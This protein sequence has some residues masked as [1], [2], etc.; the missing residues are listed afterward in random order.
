MRQDKLEGA[1][2]SIRGRF[3]KDAIQLGGFLDNDLGLSG[4][5]NKLEE[6]D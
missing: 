2:R 3:G 6:D 4:S 1:L 5:G